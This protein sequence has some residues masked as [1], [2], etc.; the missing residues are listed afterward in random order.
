M[1]TARFDDRYQL[2][3]PAG[4]A[5]AHRR[6]TASRADGSTL[7]GTSDAQGYIDLQR[8]DVSETLSFEFLDG[9]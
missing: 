7:S 1:P 3:D 8:S 2:V 4:Q 9:K 6:W 5:L